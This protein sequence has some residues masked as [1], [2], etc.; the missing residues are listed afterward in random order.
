MSVCLW[1]C[2]IECLSLALRSHDQFQAS[3]FWIQSSNSDV[4]L[5][6]SC[7]VLLVP[8][9][10]QCSPTRPCW[11]ELVIELP[12]PSVSLSLCLSVPSG[13]AYFSRPVIGPQITWP[14]PGLSL[15]NPPSLPYGGGGGCGG[16]GGGEKM[17]PPKKNFLTPPKFLWPQFFFFKDKSR[18]PFQVSVLLSERVGVSRKRDFFYV[19]VLCSPILK[20]VL[21][22]YI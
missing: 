11:A 22:K 18:N 9:G 8:F 20:A 15:L 6:V 21:L 2:A 16:G 3:H 17:T 4:R 13:A 12:C 14:D 19:A 10:M 5:Y 7:S 1:L